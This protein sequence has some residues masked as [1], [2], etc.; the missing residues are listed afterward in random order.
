M[1]ILIFQRKHTLFSSEILLYLLKVD[2]YFVM[3]YNFFESS[4][5]I[6]KREV[7]SM[8]KILTGYCRV[9]D[10][11]R[12]V[13]AEYDE[14]WDIDCQFPHCGFAGDCTIGKQLQELTVQQEDPQ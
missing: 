8:E 10:S 9:L 11:A 6:S 14:Q 7:E 1:R 4:L 12:T 13:M 3:V 5:I 2:N